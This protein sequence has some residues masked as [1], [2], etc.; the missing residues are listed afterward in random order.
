MIGLGDFWLPSGSILRLPGF[1]KVRHRATRNLDFRRQGGRK[2][3]Q[4]EFGEF[5][6]GDE[7][8]FSLFYD[9]LWTVYT[10]CIDISCFMIHEFMTFKKNYRIYILVG[11]FNPSE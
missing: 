5:T 2:L 10:V 8:V 9:V 3:P 6:Q 4:K 1:S 11:G 7:V